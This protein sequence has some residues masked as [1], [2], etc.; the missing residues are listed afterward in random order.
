MSRCWLNLALAGALVMALPMP[1]LAVQAIEDH[2]PQFITAIGDGSV[3]YWMAFEA[4]NSMELNGIFYRDRSPSQKAVLSRAAL[5]HYVPVR[6][7]I[8]FANRWRAD[9]EW[10][11]ERLEGLSGR[12]PY[13]TASMWYTY[14]TRPYVYVD[15]GGK[16]V[17]GLNAR[18]FLPYEPIKTRMMFCDAFFNTFQLQHTHDMAEH[19]TLGRRVQIEGLKMAVQMRGV[20]NLPAYSYLHVSASTLAAWQRNQK[21]I[22]RAMMK[23]IDAPESANAMERFFGRGWGDPWP[24]GAGKYVAYMLAVGA[25]REHNPL[26][27]VGMPSRD[28]MFVVRPALEDMARVQEGLSP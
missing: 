7:L 5:G 21:S 11:A 22:A 3:D 4:A 26:E 23:S 25:A 8:T 20:P 27:L 6:Q 17:L 28:Y 1:A 15:A 2:L 16:Q 13:I 10:V 19:L 9:F 14:D 18:M 24:A 12:L